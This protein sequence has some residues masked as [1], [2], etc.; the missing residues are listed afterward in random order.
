M[1]LKESMELAGRNLL[2]VLSPSHGHLPYFWMQFDK[3]KRARMEMF[4]AS[5]NVGRW[6]DAM[7][8]LEAAT[9]FPIPGEIEAAMLENLKSCLDGP[10]STCRHLP[11]ACAFD[12]HS[13]RETFLA[14]AALVRFRGSAWAREKGGRLARAL[15]QYILADGSWDKG[16]MDRLAKAAGMTVE[17]PKDYMKYFNWHPLATHGRMLEGL[18]EFHCASGDEA[19]IRLAHR[20]ASFHLEHSTRPDGGVPPAEYTHTHSL[21]GLYR[22]LL[23]YGKETGKREYI[24]R[25]AMAYDKAVRP[26]FKPSGFISH[27]WG[28]E[29]RGE[30]TAP[31]DAAQLALWLTQAGQGD[32]L[33]DAEK[34]V[35]SRIL[36][37]QITGAPGL[38][39]QADSGRDEYMNLDARAL[40]AFGGMHLY[41]HG[42]KLPTTDITAADLHT[43]C[44]IY[45][46]I[47]ESTDKGL[48]VNFHF[49]YED[50]RMTI[51]SDTGK[52]RRLL[53]DNKS[54]KPLH[55]RMPAWTGQPRFYR[56]GPE[57]KT[58][59]IEYEL[60][61][62]MIEE[63]LEGVTFRIKWKGDEITGI[64]PN[65]D[66]LPFYPTLAS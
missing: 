38:A 40:G 43:L 35:R 14:L 59:R 49:D 13:H 41:P 10:L 64:S 46:H 2:A 12:G 65:T 7:L 15:D 44:D 47:A 62:K 19:S 23:R 5:H 31:G 16:T 48:R 32:F 63:T 66:F 36:P 39:S 11:E 4:W 50:E 26:N 6:W 56:Y 54:A 33:D 20:L 55:I 30:T 9:G 21:L 57:K 45:T 3:R 42:G 27:D 60:P 22:G 18:L 24:E 61:E 53:I 29:S 58:V 52:T 28:R 8:R 34:W 37:S 17:H 25:V 1:T 51:K